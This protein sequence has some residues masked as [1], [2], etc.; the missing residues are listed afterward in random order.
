MPAKTSARI[1]ARI[2]VIT[3]G[4]A[5]MERAVRFYRDGLNLP[6]REDKPPVVYFSLAGTWLAVFPKEGLRKYIGLERPFGEAPE[7]VTLSCNVADKDEV[8]AW[9]QRA[10]AAGAEIVCA[11][12]NFGWGGY[13][14]WFA[15]LDGHLWEIVWNPRPFMD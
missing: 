8:D 3:L 15:D 10:G 14:G 1:S 9:M 2:S 6:C 4:V 12:K 11:A 5:D 7:S 13:A